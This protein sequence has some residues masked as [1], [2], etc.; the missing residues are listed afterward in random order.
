[1]NANTE[2][3]SKPACYNPPMLEKYL[4]EIGLSD[5]EAAV[6]LAL[7]QYDS[8]TPSEIAE[9]TDIKRSTVYV[10]LESLEKKGLA[11]EATEGKT[12]RYQAAPPERLETYVEREKLKYEERAERI[13]DIVPQIKAVQRETGVR[14]LVK[15]YEGA[16]GII[17]SLEEFYNPSEMRKGGTAYFIYP[18]D[19]IEE[20]FTPKERERYQKFRLDSSVSSK[21]IYTYTKGEVVSEDAAQRFRIDEQKYPLSCDIAIYDDRVKISILGR[22]LSSILIRSK[23][24]A[25]TLQSILELLHDK[26]KSQ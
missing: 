1:M 12:L 15:Y 4:E 17:S 14:P 9:K 20:V 5:K 25:Q 11:S 24:V 2:Q 7:L 13:R 22:P 6:Y 26:L 16:N 3:R 8:A 23:D 21:A 19:T 10:V 18:R